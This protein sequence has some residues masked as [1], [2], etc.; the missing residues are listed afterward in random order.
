MTDAFDE[1]EALLRSAESYVRP[2]ED[3]RSRII[4][5]ARIECRERRVVGI[6]RTIAV[7]LVSLGLLTSAMRHGIAENSTRPAGAV[8]ASVLG[9][10]SVV[11]DD[12]QQRRDST[13]DAVDELSELRIR[14]AEILRLA[15]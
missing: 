4:E 13:W 2:S 7:G 14:Q 11:P 5:T 12:Q 15:R 1:L 8:A 9:R 10:G 3:L 6:M